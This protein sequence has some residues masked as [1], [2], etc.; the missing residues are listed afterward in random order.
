MTITG[1]NAPRRATRPKKQIE[2]RDQRRVVAELRRAR[3]RILFNLQ[4][5][6]LPLT[7]KVIK[8]ALAEG[9]QKGCPDLMIF[10]PPPNEPEARGV[11]LEMKVESKKPKTDRAHRFSGAEPHQREYLEALEG[12]GWVCIVAYGWGDA[13]E[14]LADLGYDVRRDAG[15]SWVPPGE[16]A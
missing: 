6:G 13:L 5:N 11:A 1:N 9:M 3:P 14:Q 12:V 2:S 10:T 7:P 15:F 4:A 8:T 16:R